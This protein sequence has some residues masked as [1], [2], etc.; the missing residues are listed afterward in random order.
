MNSNERKIVALIV[1]VIIVI[2][3]LAYTVEAQE[4]AQLSTVWI[5]TVVVASQGVAGFT[6]VSWYRLDI[7]DSIRIVTG[8]AGTDTV[9]L[10]QDWSSRFRGLTLQEVWR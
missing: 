1:V 5:D 4:L 6:P 7:P 3:V 2:L 10:R 8:V 9:E